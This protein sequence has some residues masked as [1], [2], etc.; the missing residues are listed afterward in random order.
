MS[1][2]YNKAN[3]ELNEFLDW[4]CT[5]R[6]NRGLIDKDEMSLPERIALAGRAACIA[7]KNLAAAL[8]ELGKSLSR[9][10]IENDPCKVSIARAEIL[11][12]TIKKS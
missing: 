7:G 9:I 6:I 11:T 4:S 1:F 2:D 10:K 3:K 12:N 8:A 5:F